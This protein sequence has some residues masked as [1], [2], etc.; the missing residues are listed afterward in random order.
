MMAG[1]DWGKMPA[2]GVCE[3]PTCSAIEGRTTWLFGRHEIGFP[4]DPDDFDFESERVG[5]WHW[6][7]MEYTDKEKGIHLRQAVDFPAK[8]LTEIMKLKGKA[9]LRVWLRERIYKMIRKEN[10]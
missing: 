4:S 5:P 7:S 2:E 6:L 9:L 3:C 10:R 1:Y 8:D